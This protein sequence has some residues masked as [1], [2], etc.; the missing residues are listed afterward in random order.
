VSDKRR[1]QIPQEFILG[2][3]P[4][5]S[6]KKFIDLRPNKPAAPDATIG[7]MPTP[8][9]RSQQ[10][11]QAP[12]TNNYPN[13]LMEPRGINQPM[14]TPRRGDLITPTA[15]DTAKDLTKKAVGG[16]FGSTP[17]EIAIGA[18]L[19]IGIPVVGTV[20]SKTVKGI[21][22]AGKSMRQSYKHA[23]SMVPGNRPP[24]P[25]T[26]TAPANPS[27]VEGRRNVLKGG[28]VLAAGGAA[29]ASKNMEQVVDFGQQV[30]R[31]VK[32]QGRRLIPKGWIG[33]SATTSMDR[34][35]KASDDYFRETSGMEWF[36]KE[37]GH[38]SHPGSGS[39][40]E[41]IANL[42]DDG[43]EL[44]D[45]VF[46]VNMVKIPAQDKTIPKIIGQTGKTK[47][48]ITKEL[49][50]Y[51][52]EADYVHYS[53]MEIAAESHPDEFLYGQGK[54]FLEQSAR[55]IAEKTR[56]HIPEKLKPLMDINTDMI[57]QT[58][59][60]NILKE[61]RKQGYKTKSPMGFTDLDDVVLE[62]GKNATSKKEHL[63]IIKKLRDDADRSR[64][65]LLEETKD[66]EKGIT[67]EGFEG[68][69]PER[70]KDAQRA[71]ISSRK[72]S[73]KSYTERAIKE[74]KKFDARYDLPEQMISEVEI[75]N[76]LKQNARNKRQYQFKEDLESLRRG[77]DINKS[78]KEQ[79]LRKQF[80]DDLKIIDQA[81][82]TRGRYAQ[83]RTP[84]V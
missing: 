57:M 76:I 59:T 7:P 49:R 1:S 31:G 32:G 69:T 79:Q 36:N 35:N 15:G 38:D 5:P 28:L 78:V 40:A 68:Q 42:L 29:A 44:S 51:A 54:E 6:P 82:R 39:V 46:G 9:V 17:K 45:I 60:S 41:G 52:E 30:L 18:A 50:E 48:Q 63:E 64:R 12:V 73:I 14:A 4:T 37:F 83:N 77:T 11:R 72:G 10:K 19:E 58:M 74:Q 55:E 56:A 8:A 20:L 24:R 80:E 33:K 23:D 61:M 34:L 13:P 70:I 22:G 75:R 3:G 16:Y 62:V 27:D 65:K 25:K 43:N 67:P 26:P 84:I 21:Y 81:K 2:M 66:F 47:Q 71:R 53:L